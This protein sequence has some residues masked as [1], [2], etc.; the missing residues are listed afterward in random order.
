MMSNDFK[1]KWKCKCGCISKQSHKSRW[2]FISK[3]NR[4]YS[5]KYNNLKKD[6]LNSESSL[7]KKLRIIHSK[8]NNNLEL[9]VPNRKVKYDEITKQIVLDI[10]KSEQ[11]ESSEQIEQIKVKQQKKIIIKKDLIELNKLFGHTCQRIK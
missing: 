7:M 6:D 5:F 4:N 9:C 10:E 3:Y 2:A 8:T 1:E 11:I